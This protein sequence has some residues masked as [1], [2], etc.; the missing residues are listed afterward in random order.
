[1]IKINVSMCP[2]QLIPDIRRPL[3]VMMMGLLDFVIYLLMMIQL[4]GLR[5]IGKGL[6][7]E[8]EAELYETLYLLHSDPLFY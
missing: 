7:L 3:I 8:V 1:M 5:E 4:I 6:M 2:L